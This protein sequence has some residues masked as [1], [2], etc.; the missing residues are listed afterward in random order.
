MSP[1]H[2]LRPEIQE[3]LGE[4]ILWTWG[5]SWRKSSMRKN[6]GLISHVNLHL[7]LRILFQR[8]FKGKLIWPN[9]WESQKWHSYQSFFE[10]V[11]NIIVSML[12]ILKVEENSFYLVSYSD[13][14]KI[15]YLFLFPHFSPF[16]KSQITS[17][18]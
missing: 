16:F 9:M 8:G 1:S 3:I 10:V 4:K 18:N 13:F 6:L 2:S 11:S 14:T 15:P 7:K 12:L 17:V 5:Y